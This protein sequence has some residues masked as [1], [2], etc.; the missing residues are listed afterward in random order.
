MVGAAAHRPCSSVL[1]VNFVVFEL[2]L[3]D[4]KPDPVTWVSRAERQ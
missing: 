4:G 3:I 2:D 1:L